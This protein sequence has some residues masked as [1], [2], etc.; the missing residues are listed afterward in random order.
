[1]Q[2]YV[3][4]PKDYIPA[5]TEFYLRSQ[6]IFDKDGNPV[7]TKPSSTQYKIHIN[8]NDVSFVHN[9]DA[10]I[11]FIKKQGEAFDIIGFKHINDTANTVEYNPK[12]QLATDVKLALEYI[13]GNDID[14]A[15][16]VIQDI[17]SPDMKAWLIQCLTHGI[18]DDQCN[19]KIQECESCIRSMMRFIGQAQ[20]TIYLFEQTD[21]NKIAEFC[22]LLHAELIRLGIE[23]GTIA[24]TDLQIV[25]KSN[26]IT[27]RQQ[28]FN[29]EPDGYVGGT[30][31]DPKVEQAN[32][33]RLKE[34]AQKCLLYKTLVAK[35]N[36]DPAL[37][38]D[39]KE[40]SPSPPQSAVSATS[41]SAAGI[42]TNAS[43]AT[44]F[45]AG[46]GAGA[47][48]AAAGAPKTTP[49]PSPPNTPPTPKAPP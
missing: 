15:R 45:G 22:K 27:F 5:F 28:A 43:N 31:D 41:I 4:M 21:A 25:N 35:A 44:V 16:E 30:E 18:S 34:E 26:L 17:K 47:A 24:N 6:T 33:Q 12:Y 39:T 37:G 10:I 3:Q 36:A 13:I 1:M 46:A 29:D 9:R 14:G 48:A 7:D 8:L 2:S 49:T 40:D 23:A 20:F 19:K 42:L 38:K 32:A 11:E